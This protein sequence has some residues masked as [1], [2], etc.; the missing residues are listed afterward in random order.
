MQHRVVLERIVDWTCPPCGLTDQS[1]VPVANIGGG[2]ARLHP[3]RAFGG[4]LSPMVPTGT[5]VKITA[6]ER[7]DYIGQD[8]VQLNASGRPI[9]SITVERED[10]LDTVVFAPTATASARSLDARA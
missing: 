2:A 5:K 10:G 3:C 7:E 8:R 4:M 9:M 1:K 6:H